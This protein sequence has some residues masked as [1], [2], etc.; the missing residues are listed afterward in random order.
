MEPFKEQEPEPFK[1]PE[2]EPLRE[3]VPEP[4]KLKNQ[5]LETGVEPFKEPVQK[6]ICYLG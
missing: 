1:D 6:I 4:F 2:P 3:P 5:S